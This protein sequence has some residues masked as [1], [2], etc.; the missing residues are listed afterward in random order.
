[1]PRYSLHI[2]R[3]PVM[4]WVIASIVVVSIY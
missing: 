1:V 2:K 4:L 3:T